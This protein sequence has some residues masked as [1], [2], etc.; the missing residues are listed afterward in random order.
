MSCGLRKSETSIGRAGYETK[1]L[2]VQ[3]RVLRTRHQSDDRL[4]ELTPGLVGIHP[5]HSEVV[6]GISYEKWATCDN[7]EYQKSYL[8]DDE[9]DPPYGFVWQWTVTGGA[10]GK[11]LC[12]DCDDA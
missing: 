3:E 4:S 6:M 1:S 12:W 2:L 5:V 9:D 11:L 10:R 8:G 7:C